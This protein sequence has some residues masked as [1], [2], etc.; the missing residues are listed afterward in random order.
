[1]IDARTISFLDISYVVFYPAS[2][3]SL[4]S[5][6]TQESALLSGNKRLIIGAC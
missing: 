3:L 5:E 6:N 4:L 2:S 1:M